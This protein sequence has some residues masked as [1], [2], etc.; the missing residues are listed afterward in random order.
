MQYPYVIKRFLEPLRSNDV[1]HKVFHSKTQVELEDII[2]THIGQLNERS[3]NHINIQHIKNKLLGI[4]TLFG[5]NKNSYYLLKNNLIPK[6]EKNKKKVKLVCIEEDNFK[7]PLRQLVSD[8]ILFNSL[9]NVNPTTDNSRKSVALWNV[10]ASIATVLELII[11]ILNDNY[12]SNHML[13]QVAIL[14]FLPAVAITSITKSRNE[15][16]RLL[17]E[18]ID[19]LESNGAEE[20]IERFFSSIYTAISRKTIKRNSTR[21]ILTK[22]IVLIENLSTLGN[23]LKQYLL[24]VLTYPHKAGSLENKIWICFENQED[25]YIFKFQNAIE[26]YN[27]RLFNFYLYRQFPLN[28]D[29]IEKISFELNLHYDVQRDFFK[30]VGIDYLLQPLY[31]EATQNGTNSAPSYSPDQS[32]K[33]QRTLMRTLAVDTNINAIY[34]YSKLSGDFLQIFRNQDVK[35]LFYRSKSYGLLNTPNA[36]R[37]FSMKGAAKTDPNKL[38]AQ[39]VSAFSGWMIEMKSEFASIKY[40]RCSYLLY[41]AADQIIRQ[42]Y[43]NIK[44]DLDLWVL[45]YLI[46]HPLVLESYAFAWYDFAMLFLSI[47]TSCLNDLSLYLC[48]SNNMLGLMEKSG[49]FMFHIA[50]LS[51]VTQ[52]LSEQKQLVSFVHNEYF[53]DYQNHFFHLLLTNSSD[54]CIGLHYKYIQ[55]FAAKKHPAEVKSSNDVGILDFNV[56]FQSRTHGFARLNHYT[57]LMYQQN[58]PCLNYY[59]GIQYL[60]GFI[61][62]DGEG[63]SYINLFHKKMKHFNILSDVSMHSNY[64]LS[65]Y[66]QM[67]FS[68]IQLMKIALSPSFVRSKANDNSTVIRYSND[69]VKEWSSISKQARSAIEL[70]LHQSSK[71]FRALVFVCRDLVDFADMAFNTI[72]SALNRSA[73]KDTSNVK[74]ELDKLLLD[75]I[76][77]SCSQVGIIQVIYYLSMLNRDSVLYYNLESELKNLNPESSQ[78]TSVISLLKFEVFL[79]KTRVLDSCVVPCYYNFLLNGPFREDVKISCILKHL[80]KGAVGVEILYS[81][82]K[83]NRSTTKLYVLSALESLLCSDTLDVDDVYSILL[84]GHKLKDSELCHDMNALICEIASQKNEQSYDS[85]ALFSKAY[86]VNDI[87]EKITLEMLDYNLKKLPLGSFRT[88][89]LSQYVNHDIKYALLL[90]QHLDSYI[91]DSSTA[92]R[93]ILLSYFRLAKRDNFT[94]DERVK[95]VFI[96]SLNSPCLETKMDCVLLSSTIHELDDPAYNQ[97]NLMAREKLFYLEYIEFLS[98]MFYTATTLPF[99]VLGYNDMLLSELIDVT[100]GLTL[101]SNNDSSYLFESCFEQN[102]YRADIYNLAVSICSTKQIIGIRETDNKKAIIYESML[103]LKYLCKFSEPNEESSNETIREFLVNQYNWSKQ[104]LT[105]LISQEKIDEMRKHNYREAIDTFDNCLV[106]SC[107]IL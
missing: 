82:I 14:L 102:T 48:V 90:P 43:S 24:F 36:D 97:F 42:N 107:L 73:N 13:I 105:V 63:F 61:Q 28:T 85:F 83:S 20:D 69:Y 81:F 8:R 79:Q 22:E 32:L 99:C 5:D 59:L 51:K 101:R 77:V 12:L 31:R 65:N 49:C 6:T 18:Q 15:K 62:G 104:L 44:C 39:I 29:E 33:I 11:I 53:H 34:I 2:V 25:P 72:L 38:S 84:T 67:M 50:I 41:K 55:L 35:E 30:Q 47:D 9:K 10:A 21:S 45:M 76:I 60:Y 87:E 74:T 78:S 58:D 52:V 106:A 27:P 17:K 57:E 7:H 26:Q 19:N 89:Y 3:D 66:I 95:N 93:A 88:G 100:N 91:D 56:F 94:I 23:L 37:L 70:Q 68:L 98:T 54:V 92:G 40:Y 71:W 16:K 1:Y 46:D 96:K 103:A 86:L 75:E 80:Q 4:S 64:P